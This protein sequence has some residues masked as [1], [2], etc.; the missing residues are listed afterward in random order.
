MD[1]KTGDLSSEAKALLV[2]PKRGFGLS[3]F[4]HIAGLAGEQIE[5]PEVPL[6]GDVGNVPLGSENAEEPAG[7]RDERSRLDGANSSLAQDG[8]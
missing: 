4:D 8:K 5:A 6:I 2:V 3:G 1:T 7:A